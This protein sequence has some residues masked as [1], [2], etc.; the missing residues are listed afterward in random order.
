M[1][2]TKQG[3][4]KGQPVDYIPG[5]HGKKP[6]AVETD[7]EIP[8]GAKAIF[9]TRGKIAI[10]DAADYEHLNQFN[11]CAKKMGRTWYAVRTFKRSDGKRCE[12]KMHREV[13]NAPDGMGVD[14]M[15]GNGLN[16]TRDNLRLA[17]HRQNCFNSQSRQNSSSKYKGVN[18]H[19]QN[20]KWTAQIRINEKP[21]YL[22]IFEDEKDAARAYNAAAIKFY[23]EF[24]RLN[25]IE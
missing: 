24:A 15:D 4:V 7:I 25:D 8:K 2:R 19:R 17:T 14:H 11:W 5:H 9:L 10:V 22:G 20:R 23:G 13:M 12:S 21:L 16:N 1:T 18:W 3:H 6:R